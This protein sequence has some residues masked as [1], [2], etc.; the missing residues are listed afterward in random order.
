M[1]SHPIVHCPMA[2]I[3]LLV[4]LPVALTSTET[5]SLVSIPGMV[6][7][8]TDAAPHFTVVESVSRTRLRRHRRDVIAG[9]KHGWNSHEI[10]FHIVG[11][12][13]ESFFHSHLMQR[14]SKISYAVEFTC[15][16]AFAF[17]SNSGGKRPP[18]CVS[19]RTRKRAMGSG[20]ISAAFFSVRYV[21]EEGDAC[22]TEFIG[23]NGGYQ[24]IVI[25]SECAEV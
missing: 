18:V 6:S 14:I 22:F 5:V 11:G 9:K 1:A 24:D 20:L 23:R 2:A 15:K 19:E 8:S 25:G 12:D 16:I 17:F 7:M 13:G 4:L 21:L 10:P 3:L